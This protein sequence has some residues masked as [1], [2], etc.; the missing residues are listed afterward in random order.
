MLYATY[1][2]YWAALILK[3]LIFWSS[4]WIS[5]SQTS[6]LN[7]SIQSCDVILRKFFSLLI[8]PIIFF[9][10]YILLLSSIKRT[11]ETKTVFDCSYCLCYGICFSD[12]IY[13]IQITIYYIYL[14]ILYTNYNTCKLHIIYKLTFQL[15]LS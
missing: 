14:Y 8:F 9:W 11:Y 15:Q 13:Y 10:Y 1:L 2:K 7:K 12:K 5:Y 4:N 6:W 3:L